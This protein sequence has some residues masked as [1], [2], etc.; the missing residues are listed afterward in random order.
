MYKIG[1]INYRLEED[2]A[3]TWDCVRVR[4]GK[5]FSEEAHICPQ[6]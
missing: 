3:H 6:T 5:D 1:P 4:D 2:A